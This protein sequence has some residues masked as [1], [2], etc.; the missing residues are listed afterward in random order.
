MPLTGSGN[1]LGS[2]IW[3]AIKALPWVDSSKL[4]V[5]EEAMEIELWQTVA[6]VI[7]AHIIANSDIPVTPG[8]F[9]VTHEGPRAVNGLGDGEII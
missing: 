4:S 6:S 8:T 2:A 3:T 7:V 9:I 1:V 5:T